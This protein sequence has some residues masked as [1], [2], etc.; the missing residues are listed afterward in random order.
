MGLLLGVVIGLSPWFYDEPTVPA[1]LSLAQLEIVRLRRWEEVAQ[2]DCCISLSKEVAAY[3]ASPE[4]LRVSNK[5]I[6]EGI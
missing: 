3:L 6:A 1:V 2:G 5:E 4:M